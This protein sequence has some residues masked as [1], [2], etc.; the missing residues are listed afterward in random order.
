MWCN[1]EIE[2]TE[3]F[4]LRCHFYS[5]QKFEFSRNINKVV[6]SFTQLGTKEQ[7]NIML[8]GY[9]LNKSNTLNQD[10]IKFLINFIKKM[11][12]LIKHLVSFNQWFCKLIF[13]F[14]SICY[15]ALYAIISVLKK[16]VSLLLIAGYKSILLIHFF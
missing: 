7:V 11:V 15:Y 1:D 3:N 9:P 5:V 13:F 2:N 6:L 14:L 10:I 4:F 8:Y 16:I 12:P